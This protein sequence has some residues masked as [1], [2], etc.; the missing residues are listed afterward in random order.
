[1]LTT[2]PRD[3]AQ[4]LGVAPSP[5][6]PPWGS[7]TVPSYTNYDAVQHGL[8]TRVP[9]ADFRLRDQRGRPLTGGP[10]SAK[11]YQRLM[12]PTSWLTGVLKAL[13]EIPDEIPEDGLPGIDRTTL[14]EADRIIRGLARHPQPPTVYPTTDAEIAIHFRAADSASSVAI[15]LNDRG[16]AECFAYTHGRSRHAHYDASADLPD[17]F[18]MAQLRALVPRRQFSTAWKV[19]IGAATTLLFPN[20]WNVP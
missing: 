1:M 4:D 20:L 17:D 13:A 7:V 14:E 6:T 3:S 9:L 18:V 10:A 19:E 5:R 8:R 11:T 16:Q 15:L 12:R 2:R